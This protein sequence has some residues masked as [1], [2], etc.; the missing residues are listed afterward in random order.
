MARQT[1]TRLLCD[2]CAQTNKTVDGEEHR[3]SID[4]LTAVV[5]LC[6]RCRTRVLDPLTTIAQ[7]A[8]K[9]SAAASARPAAPPAAPTPVRR[10]ERPRVTFP[11]EPD[12]V[13][14]HSCVPPVGMTSEQRYAHVSRVHPGRRVWDLTWVGLPSSGMEAC[15]AP[16]CHGY[17]VAGVLGMA[18]HARHAHPDNPNA[19][20]E[21][22]RRTHHGK[23]ARGEPAGPTPVAR[24]VVIG[25]AQPLSL[26]N[27]ANAG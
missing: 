6:R 16:D 9:A 8:L 24:P 21:F 5:I 22:A 10:S 11:A 4:T 2:R 19:L 20:A 7:A 13:Q 23:P 1:I 25:P 14:C 3:I 15:P 12:T 17:P 18:A 27:P 26:P